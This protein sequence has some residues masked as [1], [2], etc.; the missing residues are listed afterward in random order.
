M[1]HTCGVLAPRHANVNCFNAKIQVVFALVC[2]S[3]C[4]LRCWR[5]Y[6]HSKTESVPRLLPASAQLCFFTLPFVPRRV[7]PLTCTAGEAC[8]EKTAK[9]SCFH[10]G[11]TLGEAPRGAT[12]QG[13]VILVPSAGPVLVRG[14]SGSY[15]PFCLSL[16]KC[17]NVKSLF[18]YKL[19]FQR[20]RALPGRKRGG[21]T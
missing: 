5:I 3:C 11:N 16:L 18:L 21:N 10:E 12:H 4:S 19:I 6:Q 20:K 2:R 1:K 15:S 13:L 14:T 9:G 7:T 8:S 17:I